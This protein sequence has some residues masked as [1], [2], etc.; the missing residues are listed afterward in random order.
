MSTEVTEENISI[1]TDEIQH[2]FEA[3][4]KDILF[5]FN[6]EMLALENDINKEEK[7]T[8]VDRKDTPEKL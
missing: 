5:T 3:K 8:L 2:L 6:D 4:I 7:N 1:R